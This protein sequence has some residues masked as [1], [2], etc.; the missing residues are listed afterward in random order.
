MSHKKEQPDRSP[1]RRQSARRAQE[2]RIERMMIWGAVALGVV[3]LLLLGYGVIKQLVIDEHQAVAQV[4]ETTITAGEYQRRVKYER[5]LVRGRVNLYNNY[6][7]QFSQMDPENAASF[8]QQLQFEVA[9]LQNQLKPE[10]ATLFG[11]NVLDTMAEEELVR[12]EAA[13]RGIIV[14]PEQLEE[15]IRQ[16]L[17]EQ[18]YLTEPTTFTETTTLTETASSIT[19]DYATGYANFLRDI[20]RVT[21]LKQAEFEAMEQAALLREALKLVLG[22]D[23]VTT[24]TQ[25]EFS[26]LVTGDEESALA[27]Q[28]RVNDG[29][30]IAALILELQESADP[31]IN[32]GEVPWLAAGVIAQQLGTELEQVAFNAPLNQA[33]DP[34]QALDG[35]FYVLYITGREENRPLDEFTLSQR[36]DEQYNGW[37][38]QQRESQVT[39]F[40]VWEK[41]TPS[42]PGL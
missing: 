9:T 22:Q 36:R 37:L 8:T 23:I 24:A 32:G 42:E 25:V 28:T 35:N 19:T 27:L 4:G 26:Y 40:P 10:L 41:L 3:I 39:R 38:I 6:I 2:Q 15:T 18:G 17:L 34:I 5:V 13:A 33:I 11:G 1:T 20:R 7:A 21:Q 31:L 16:T 14:T 30:D 12:Q 29:E